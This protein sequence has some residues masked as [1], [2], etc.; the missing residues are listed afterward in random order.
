MSYKNNGKFPANFRRHLADYL[1]ID[2]IG[3]DRKRLERDP[4]FY[5]DTSATE[6]DPVDATALAKDQS[7]TAERK[8]VMLRGNKLG[9]GTLNRDMP[10][11]T[12]A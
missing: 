3:K 11:R 10:S 5:N 7:D 4:D 9:V 8:D 6:P 1:S 2:S 12:S